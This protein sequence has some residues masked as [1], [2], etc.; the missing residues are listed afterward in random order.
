MDKLK[1]I[2]T[3]IAS[4]LLRGATITSNPGNIKMDEKQERNEK[5]KDQ[6]VLFEISSEAVHRLLEM[7]VEGTHRALTDAMK[8]LGDAR[9]EMWKKSKKTVDIK[10]EKR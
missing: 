8:R 7:G 10:P 9:Y 2:N 3:S 5:W 1:E 6:K 4:I